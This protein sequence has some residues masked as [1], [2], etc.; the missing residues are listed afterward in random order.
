MTHWKRRRVVRAARLLVS[1]FR[2]K[3]ETTMA[4]QLQNTDECDITLE[5]FNAADEPVGID[6]IDGI[7]EWGNSGEATAATLTVASDGGSAVLRSID[8]AGIG[9]PAS[10]T[11]T[12]DFDGDKGAGVR[13]FHLEGD[14]QVAAA[15]GIFRANVVF[16]APRVK[17]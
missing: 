8:G 13:Q 14:Y 9:T 11:I 4:F 7:P 1:G 2:A 3:G 5:L 10:G 16:G 17:V 6:E 12:V 15:G